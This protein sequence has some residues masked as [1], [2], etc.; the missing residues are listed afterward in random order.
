MPLSVSVNSAYATAAVK[1]QRY[2]GVPGF[3][4]ANSILR[5]GFKTGIT[6]TS[7]ATINGSIP[8]FIKER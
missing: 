2:L 8:A 4:L 1:P 6:A 5:Y 7:S 3:I